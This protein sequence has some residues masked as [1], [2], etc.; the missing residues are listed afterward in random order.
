MEEQRIDP[1]KL[2]QRIRLDEQTAGRG[3][4][5]IFFGYAAGVGKTY[6]MLEAAHEAK[7]QGIDTVI[8]YVEPHAR[9]QT[10]ALLAGLEQVPVKSLRYNGLQLQEMDLDALLKRAPQIALV[11][12]L[13]HTNAAGCRHEKRYQDVEELLR[14]GINV[15]A[16][17]NVQHLE[18]LNDRVESITGV[19]VRERIPDHIF[20][21]AEQVELVDIEP[22]RLLERLG[23]GQ[24]YAAEQ[25]RRA[26]AHFFTM[27]NLTAL[28][29]IALRRCADRV[30]QRVEAAEGGKQGG[31]Y[32]SEHILVCLSSSPSNAKIIRTAAR[33]AAAFKGQFTALFVETPSFATMSEENRNRLR[34]NMRL[35]QQLG[36]R[37]ETVSGDDV[38]FQIAEFARLSG[39]SK[40]VLGRSNVKRKHL[41]SPPTLTEKLVAFAPGLDIHIIPDKD[42][43]PYTE[44]RKRGATSAWNLADAW[45]SVGLLCLATAIGVLFAKVGFSEANI[46]T[47]YI[48][49]V[50]L[51]AVTTTHRLYS[52]VSSVLSVLLFNFF[53]TEPR[54]TLNVYNSGYPVTFVIMLL[55]S[56]FTS[57]LGVRM[58]RHARLSAQAAYRTKMLLETNQLLQQVKEREQIVS[59]TAKQLNR[60]LSRDVV[61]YPAEEGS[62]LPP[63]FF[64]ATEGAK[65]TE[66]LTENER[67]VAAWVLQNNKHAGATTNTLSGAKGL[68]LAVR[69]G[70][71]VYGV[72]GILIG[73]APLEPMENN[74]LLSVLGEC[75]LAL[76]NERTSHEKEEAAVLAKNEQLRADLLRSISH[77][78]R[79][80]LT[81]ISGHASNLISNAHSLD[82]ATR[83]QLYT[84]IYDDSQWLINLVENLLSVTRM[85]EGGMNLNLSTELIGEIIDEALTHMSRKSAEHHISVCYQDDYAFV[86]MD[87]HLMVQVIINIVDNAVKYTPPGS[88]ITISTKKQDG[89]VAVEVAD[90]GPG[91]SDEAKARVFDMFYTGTNQIADSR[92]SLGLGLSL[93]K[94]IVHVHG[95]EISVRDN[96]PHGTIFKVT[97]P[98]EEVQLHE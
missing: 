57:S 61:F 1:E 94:S 31:R 26:A 49:A 14:A 32:T 29:E 83:Q 24:I 43:P 21:Q 36:A 68:Y 40:I 13:A 8:G 15:F 72:V 98:I 34:S 23:E 69:V 79:T 2:L 71:T 19:T 55:A 11:D 84:D 35:V 22:S 20:D 45:K 50:L 65:P 3:K 53:F 85:E 89:F 86:K 58:K 7:Q 42:T 5:H 62:L 60:L 18:S 81:A 76:E 6:A 77:D 28:R 93:C 96:L 66:F 17:V 44:K 41:F 74:I 10:M 88:D 39:I 63:M 51:T 56:V 52:I 64:A 25:A 97:L 38:P 48:F 67:A 90:N 54:F 59:V 33:M 91:M 92:R 9:P 27:D 82:E 30:N 47:V 73:S 78:L 16:T 87:T 75:A 12:E 80:P 70:G 46:I 37:V 95:G 4:L